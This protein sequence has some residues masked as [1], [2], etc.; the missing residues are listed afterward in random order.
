MHSNNITVRHSASVMLKLCCCV[1]N[2]LHTHKWF[3]SLFSKHL[4]L[5]NR[6]KGF[7]F[8]F[9]FLYITLCTCCTTGCKC[10]NLVKKKKRTT[11]C[12]YYEKNPLWHMN[13][14][15]LTRNRK[16]KTALG[17]W[18][19]G[20]LDSLWLSMHAI[21]HWHTM[22]ANQLAFGLQKAML[23]TVVRRCD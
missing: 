11:K 4:N 12:N 8:L 22:K 3:S 16:R 7:V 1:C 13:V 21:I 5:S 14:L 15:I 19:A 9:S 23:R 10:I 2:S 20:L 6:S 18:G 17:G